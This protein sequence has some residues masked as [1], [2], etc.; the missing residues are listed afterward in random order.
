VFKT[1]FVVSFQGGG[2]A[3]VTL[4]VPKSTDIRMADPDGPGDLIEC[5]L[6]SGLWYN[7]YAVVDVAKGFSNEYR[8]AA[9]VSMNTDRNMWK[10][11]MP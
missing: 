10:F 2:A 5:P 4:A 7:V 6:G 8:L 3:S 9:M 11:P 1:G